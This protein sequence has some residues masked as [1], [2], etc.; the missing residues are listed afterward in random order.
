MQEVQ[1]DPKDLRKIAVASFMQSLKFQGERPVMDSNF[2]R[3]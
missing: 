2:L 3:R 1:F